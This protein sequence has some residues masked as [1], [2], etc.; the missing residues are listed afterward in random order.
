MLTAPRPRT[1]S[2][3]PIIDQDRVRAL[4]TE[5]L[6]I[7][8]PGDRGP[9]D[10]H[11]ERVWPAGDDSIS[12]EWTLRLADGR[13]YSLH[14]SPLR[15][16]HA[17]DD[18]R[19]ADIQDGVLRGVR[20]HATELG[21]T[22]HSP[23]LDE[24]LMQL[25]QCLDPKFVQ[26][27]CPAL[28]PA[29]SGDRDVELLAYRARRRATLCYRHGQ[30]RMVAKIFRDDRGAALFA[31]HESLGRQLLCAS[32]GL[33]RTTTP[34]AYSPDLQCLT[35]EWNA[36]QDDGE[37]HGRRLLEPIKALALL[38]RCELPNRP[39][40]S[41][42]DE[43]LVVQRWADALATWGGGE[44]GLLSKLLPIWRVQAPPA[45]DAGLIHRDYYSRQVILSDSATTLL[46]LDTLSIGDPA[47]DVGNL[48]AHQWFDAI[49]SPSHEDQRLFGGQASE[50]LD[51][52]QSTG[53]R[54]R[55]ASLRWFLASAL[56]RLGAVHALR[57]TTGRYSHAL[58]CAAADLIGAASLLPRELQGSC[59]PQLGE[60][61]E[62]VR[63]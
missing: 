31:V 63:E 6:E 11:I 32:H 44:F 15:R 16:N 22:I 28:T 8:W 3:S 40:F 45:I 29:E 7:V 51:A 13:R 54:L 47:Q 34:L 48:L 19:E 17:H 5:E 18:S 62:S 55:R 61:L 30:E 43:V 24:V 33:V 10:I 23:D 21:V 58:W 60:I 37:R 59:A 38:H 56:L 27:D 14:A 12:A 2:V 52:Y 39:R 1:S 4:L 41:P 49:R 9:E 53:G 50:S 25:P 57:T 36:P 20:I 26:N 46:D 35:L 42:S